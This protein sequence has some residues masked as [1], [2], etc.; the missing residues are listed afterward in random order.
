MTNLS[1][2]DGRRRDPVAGGTMGITNLKK[3]FLFGFAF[4]NSDFL[5]DV[6]GQNHTDL[7]NLTRF[8]VFLKFPHIVPHF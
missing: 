1:V 6:W 5:F 2:T 3:S 7:S 4:K 8:F